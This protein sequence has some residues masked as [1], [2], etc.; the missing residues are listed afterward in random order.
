M[1]LTRLANTAIDGVCGQEPAVRADIVKY[2]ACD[3]LCYRAER[4]QS[5]VRRQ[6]VAWDGVVAWAREALGIA[7]RIG[8][9][10]MP[11]AQPGEVGTAVCAALAPFDCFGLAALHVVTTLTGSALLALALARGRLSA[12]AAWAAAHVDEEFQIAQWGEDA[13]AAARRQLRWAELQAA[14]R[15]LQLLV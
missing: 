4:P 2:A 5:L 3:L 12:E 9:G 7:V 11:I 8:S 1:Q 14:S 6:C 15:M 13:E 10:V